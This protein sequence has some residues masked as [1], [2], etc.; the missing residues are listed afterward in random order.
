[1]IERDKSQLY[2]LIYASALLSSCLKSHNT[3]AVS[4]K[5]CLGGGGGGAQIFMIIFS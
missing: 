2:E 4:R 5:I 1:M 3:R